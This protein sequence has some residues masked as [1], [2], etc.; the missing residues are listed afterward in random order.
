MTRKQLKDNLIREFTFFE[1]AYFD[2]RTNKLARISF[3]YTGHGEIGFIKLIDFNLQYIE[4]FEHI[5]VELN[6]HNSTIK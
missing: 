5:F 2:D 6:K 1:L 3:Y 4:L